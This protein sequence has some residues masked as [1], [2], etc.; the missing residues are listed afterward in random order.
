MCAVQLL[1][2]ARSCSCK[3]CKS[4]HPSQTATQVNS[5]KKCGK[6]YEADN[7]QFASHLEVVVAHEFQILSSFQR[8][9]SAGQAL[10]QILLSSGPSGMLHITKCFA[11]LPSALPAP[12]RPLAGNLPQEKTLRALHENGKILGNAG[13]KPEHRDQS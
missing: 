2:L 13:N 10:L 4:R 9:L 6:K 3:R 8:N 12:T 7:S 5:V 11:K 1:P